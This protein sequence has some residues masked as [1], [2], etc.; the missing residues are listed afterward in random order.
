MK[1][2]LVAILLVL[3]SSPAWANELNSILQQAK[4]LGAPMAAVQR[5]IQISQQPIFENK[6]AL[7][8]F[9]ISQPSSKKRFY[10]LD[11]KS[12]QV[13]AH[14]AAHGR[15]NGPNARATKFKGFQTHLD[16]VPLGPLKTAHSEVMDHYKTIVDRYDGTV[17]RDMIVLVLEG[18]ASYNSY[19]NNTPPFKWIIHPNW[20]TTAGFRAKNNGVLGRSNGCITIDPAENNQLITRLQD[21]ALVYVTV[22]DAPIEEYL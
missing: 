11:F 5:A 21:G 3:I 15:D 12:G 6:D 2:Y 13:T 4:A 19:I 10:V 18:V 20:Y 16:M 7:A 8:V 17:Y 14:Y 1:R 9:D 22:G